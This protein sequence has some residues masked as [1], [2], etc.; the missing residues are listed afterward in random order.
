MIQ[1]KK[2]EGLVAPAFTPFTKNDEINSGI[3]P[4]YAEQLKRK[5]LKGVFILGSSGEGML[6]SVPERLE[7]ID[8]WAKER[9]QQFKL[10]V[11]IGANSYKDSQVL[12][13]HAKKVGVDALSLMGPTFLQPKTVKELVAY[14]KVIADTIPDIPVY[15]YH[16]PIRTGINFNMIDLLREA[17]DKIPNL[18]GIKYTNSNFMDMQRCINFENGQ[19]DI[20]HGS[21]ETLLCGLSIGIKGGIGTTY[22]L[23]P[24]V[25]YDIIEAYNNNETERARKLQLKSVILL[26]IISRHGGG[27]VAGKHLMKIAQID[28]GPCRIPLQTIELP[29]TVEMENDLKDN[30]L[31]DMIANAFTHSSV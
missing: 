2:I 30:H 20:L 29:E 17:K 22:N 25:Y 5:R 19:Y 21:D 7:V 28:C 8:A 4:L 18:V 11:H 26:N 12:A 27:I 13:A 6:M 3:I 9:T 1:F 14:I 24:E 31:Y 16:I 15:Y 10:I 23:I